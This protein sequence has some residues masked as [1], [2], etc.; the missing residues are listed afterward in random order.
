M[1]SAVLTYSDLSPDMAYRVVSGDNGTLAAG[2]IIWVDSISKALNNATAQG[3]LDAEE[4][5]DEIFSNIIIESAPE[6]AVLTQKGN[7]SRCFPIDK[8]ST[9]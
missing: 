5:T 6:Y 2:D 3:W 8:L 9:W 7:G 4:C 1:K